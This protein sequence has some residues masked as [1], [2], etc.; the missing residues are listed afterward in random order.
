MVFL[1]KFNLVVLVILCWNVGKPCPLGQWFFI[2]PLMDFKRQH[3][4]GQVDNITPFTHQTIACK[5]DIVYQLNHFTLGGF[6]NVCQNVCTR[7]AGITVELNLFQFPSKCISTF[8]SR[9]VLSTECQHVTPGT[10]GIPIGM[11][12]LCNLVFPT[13]FNRYQLPCSHVVLPYC[14]DVMML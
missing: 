2:E 5:V 9:E 4:G 6:H 10:T 3:I 14:Y 1:H 11:S 7:D 8:W 12:L 13:R